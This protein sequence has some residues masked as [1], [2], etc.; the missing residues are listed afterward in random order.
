MLPT[1]RPGRW[2]K[3]ADA[4]DDIYRDGRI[5]PNLSAARRKAEIKQLSWPGILN[6][7]SRIYLNLLPVAR[8]QRGKHPAAN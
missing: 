2:R 5:A 4:P 8:E 1:R 3:I 6:K 7:V